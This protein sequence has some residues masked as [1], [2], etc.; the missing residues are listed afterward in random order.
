MGFVTNWIFCFPDWLNKSVGA[1]GW[2]DDVMSQVEAAYRQGELSKRQYRDI[3]D[4]FVTE[5]EPHLHDT[6]DHTGGVDCDGCGW[7]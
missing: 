1:D 7:Y 3:C 2:S 4:H 5:V 6:V